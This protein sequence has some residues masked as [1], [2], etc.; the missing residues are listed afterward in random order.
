MAIHDLTPQLRTRLHRV[1]RIVTLFVVFATI[2]LFAGFGY[3]LYDTGKRKGWF[4]PKCKYYTLLMSAEGLKVGDPIMLLGFNVGRIT[5]IETQP[6]NSYYKIFVTFD[7]R[8]PYYG[9]I[10]SDS[11]LRVS[12]GIIGGHKLEVIAGY[13]GKPTVKEVNGYPVEVLINTQM[14]AIADAPKGVYLPAADDAPIADRAQKL[15]GQVEQALPNILCITNKI[16]ATLANVVN[17]TSNINQLLVESRPIVTNVQVIT[18]NLRDPHGSL[19][20]WLI[21]TNLNGRLDTVLGSVNTTI[22]TANNTLTN[23]QNKITLTTD[24]VNHILLNVDDITATIKTQIKANDQL[25]HNVN[26]L[27]LETEDMIRGLKRH[28]LLKDA[29]PA[30]KL[31][32]PPLLLE[33]QIQRGQ[34]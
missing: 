25:L 13:D 27:L 31:E 5:H 22:G 34:P 20:N 4:I 1:E 17:I 29:F 7:V 30:Q 21:P 8:R 12:S 32:S 23:L 28:W 3:Y 10:W 15:F 9:Y 19:G 11:R 14:V 2:L 26:G 33:P 6:P 16:N 24:N 18:A